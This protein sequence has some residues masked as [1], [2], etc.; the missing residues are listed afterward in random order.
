MNDFKEGGPFGEQGRRPDIFQRARDFAGDLEHG[1]QS[2]VRLRNQFRS[3]AKIFSAMA[4]G[5]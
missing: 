5:N 4:G 2:S 1:K 3:N